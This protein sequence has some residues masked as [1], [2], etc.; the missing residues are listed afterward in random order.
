METNTKIHASIGHETYSTRITARG[1]VFY[2]DEKEDNG[3]KDLGP[4][5]TELVL[6]GLATC[7][8]ATLRMYAD[9]KGWDLDRVTLHIGIRFEKTETGQNAVIERIMEFEGSLDE[10]QRNRLFQI[11]EK[12]P[13]FK[14]LTSP[15]RIETKIK[16]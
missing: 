7:T 11:A 12:C 5:P 14:L 9:R 4:T 10:E 3:G 15:I 2:G 16:P 13:T 1:H 8:T 6:S